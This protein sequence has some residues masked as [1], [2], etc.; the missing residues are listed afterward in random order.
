MSIAAQEIN[1]DTYVAEAVC[2]DADTGY[3]A[4]QSYGRRERKGPYLEVPED[5]LHDIG[6]IHESNDVCGSRTFFQFS[7]L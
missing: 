3:F 4:G 2:A 5:T 1:R 6:V 7:A